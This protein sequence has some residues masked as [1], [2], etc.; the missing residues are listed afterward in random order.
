METTRFAYSGKD[1]LS[2]EKSMGPWWQNP[3]RMRSSMHL[4]LL[5]SI[6]STLDL[7]LR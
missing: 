5:P 7:A 1:N 4:S 6:L 3:V 2:P